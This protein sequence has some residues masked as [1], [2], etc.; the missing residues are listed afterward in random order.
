MARQ[1]GGMLPCDVQINETA[2]K[3][4]AEID[5]QTKAEGAGAIVSLERLG[6]AVGVSR[7]TTRR[8]CRVLEDQGLLEVNQR[9][10]TSG[11]RLE[12]EYLVTDKGREVL[13]A[14]ERIRI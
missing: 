13:E 9:Y 11:G 12:N 4:L 5:R 7:S 8:N 10:S 6:D 14:A 2:L 1:M 3:I